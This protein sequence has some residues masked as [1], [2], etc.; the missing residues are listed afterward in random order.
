MNGISKGLVVVSSASVTVH[1]L[2]SVESDRLFDQTLDVVM[3]KEV[4]KGN[5]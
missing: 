2:I 1:S 4:I 3:L 5:F